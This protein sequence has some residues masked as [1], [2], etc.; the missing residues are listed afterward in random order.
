MRVLPCVLDDDLSPTTT[1][2]PLFHYTVSESA[3]TVNIDRDQLTGSINWW[4]GVDIW[5]GVG[6]ISHHA[7]D[8][9]FMVDVCPGPF[10]T[11]YGTI[12]QWSFFWTS[13][14]NVVD[15]FFFVTNP[16]RLLISTNFFWSNSKIRFFLRQN[17]FFPRKSPLRIGFPNASTEVVHRPTSRS[18]LHFDMR[19]I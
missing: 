5:I 9:D 14:Q 6:T 15:P 4:I 2:L 8:H 3:S 10:L 12:G 13:R 18:R 16:H 17:T 7:W 1:A 11:T 19:N